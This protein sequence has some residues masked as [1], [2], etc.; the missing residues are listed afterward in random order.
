MTLFSSLFRHGAETVE[1][2]GSGPS[3]P[4]MSAA[5]RG[6][7]YR[8]GDTDEGGSEMVRGL[9]MAQGGPKQVRPSCT[10]SL[11]IGLREMWL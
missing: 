3:Q 1:A 9:P 5:F 2:G 10:G 8:L 7:G 4:K 6:T 11:L